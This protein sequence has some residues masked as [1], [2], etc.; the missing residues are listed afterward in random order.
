MRLPEHAEHG[1]VG[2]A[3]NHRP[4]PRGRHR[5]ERRLVVAGALVA[6]TAGG[7]ATLHQPSGTAALFTSRAETQVNHIQGG[8]WAPD[9]PPAC[10]PVDHYTGVVYGT[11]GDDVLYGGNRPQIIMGLGGDDRIYGGNGG[12]CLVGGPGD[13]HLVGGNAKD[14]LLGGPGDDHLDGGNA[15]DYLDGEDDTNTCDG[16]NGRDV[17]VHCDQSVAPHTPRLLTQQETSH[18]STAPGSDPASEPGADPQAGLQPDP[19][20]LPQ[21]DPQPDPLTAPQPD[22]AGSGV[23]APLETTP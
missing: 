7:L 12:D 21:P 3:R 4:G 19:Q 13:D 14:I 8:I 16:G 15:K 10:G 22:P 9:P 18:Q 1:V 23:P 20:P 2:P 5:R 17:V 11:P 6:L